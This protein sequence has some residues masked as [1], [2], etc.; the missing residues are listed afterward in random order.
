MV[1]WYTKVSQDMTNIPDMID[2]FNG[3]LEEARGECHIKGN[4][5]RT[6]AALPGH[7]EHRFF[8]LQELEAILQYMNLELRKIRKKHFQ[9]YMEGYGRALT[10]RDAEKYVDG[11]DEVV[12]M[13]LIINE[14]A[15]VRNKY[16]GIMK[17][18]DVK[19]F[20]ISNNVRLRTSGMED[21]SL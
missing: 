14:V 8:Q 7:V 15:L 10:S 2:Y 16:L 20:Q 3:E 5:E 6:A 21:I 1:Q 11:E 19:Q 9:Y 12:D 18:M 4:L 17:A 13:E